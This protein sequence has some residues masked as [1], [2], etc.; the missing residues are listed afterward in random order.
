[1][2]P[3]MAFYSN[4]R[5]NVQGQVANESTYQYIARKSA[6]LFLDMSCM[7]LPAARFYGVIVKPCLFSTNN[8]KINIVRRL[9]VSDGGPWGAFIA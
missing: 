5:K 1:M 8:F 4:A 6:A 9:L 3:T 7:I 2:K